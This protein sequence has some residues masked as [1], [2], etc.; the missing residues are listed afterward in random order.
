MSNSAAAALEAAERRFAATLQ[1]HLENGVVFISRDVYIDPEVVIAP[2]AQILPGTILRGNTVI[3]AGCVVGPNSLLENTTL[4]A[5]STFNASQ[6]Y[7]S[8][9]GEGSRVGPFAHI[10]AGTVTDQ[11]V[12][13]GAFVETKNSQIGEGTAVSHLTYVGDSDVG[14]YCNFGCGTVTSNYD[15][16]GKHRCQIGNYA[17]LGCNTNLIAPVK[18]GDF[19]YTAA[20]ST[21]T[22]EVPQGALAIARSRQQNKEGWAAKKLGAYVAKKKKLKDETK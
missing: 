2:G 18:V 11:G 17:F 13:L 9:L 4:G 15:G 8:K 10:R 20:G 22:G 16:E 14:E 19:S 12:H 3:G 1:K 6:A 21:I 5:G 7:N